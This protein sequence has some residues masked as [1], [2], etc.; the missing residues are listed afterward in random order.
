[1]TGRDSAT[2]QYGPVTKAVSLALSAGTGTQ[3]LKIK[4]KNPG[5]ADSVRIYVKRTSASGS[6][7]QN[8]EYLGKTAN[9]LT[10]QKTIT[11]A[12]RTSNVVEITTSSAHGLSVEDPIVVSIPQTPGFSVAQTDFALVKAVPNSTKITYDSVGDDGSATITGAYLTSGGSALVGSLSTVESPTVLTSSSARGWADGEIYTAGGNNY[13]LGVGEDNVRGWLYPIS[14]FGGLFDNSW[15]SEIGL[16]TSTYVEAVDTQYR[17]SPYFQESD[18]PN[19]EQY[20]GRTIRN[21]L[22]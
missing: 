20:G 18:T 17:F 4:W 8:V 22:D 7:T 6:G 11:A 13:R 15:V 21:I 3:R 9:T 1:M 2:P 10:S 14:V 5:S 12:T 16:D 19:A